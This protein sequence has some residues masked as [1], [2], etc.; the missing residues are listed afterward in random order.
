MMSS[1]ESSPNH[2]NTSPASSPETGPSEHTHR[3]QGLRGS[4][5]RRGTG[6][7]GGISQRSKIGRRGSSSNTPWKIK[8]KVP[9][10]NKQNS[11]G[12]FSVKNLLFLDWLSN[13]GVAGRDGYCF[14][15]LFRSV[16]QGLQPSGYCL[17]FSVRAEHREDAH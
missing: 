12:W 14:F 3:P 2:V 15:S 5:R 6:G 1:Q 7:G 11:V 16:M 4:E 9:C 17:V 10:Q 13:F 8:E